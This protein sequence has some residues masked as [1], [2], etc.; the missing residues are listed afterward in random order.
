MTAFAFLFL[1]LLVL[2]QCDEPRRTYHN[3][4]VLSLEVTDVD[5]LHFLAQQYESNRSLDFW[6]EPRS[7][8]VVDLRIDPEIYD[9]FTAI[10]TEKDIPY[11]IM[12]EDVQV[13]MDQQMVGKIDAFSY[14][15]YNTLADIHTWIQS[16]PGLYPN[17]VSV[18]SVGKSFEG[19]DMLALRVTAGSGTKPRAVWFNGGIH[20][21]EWLSPATVIR[22]TYMLLESYH[23]DPEVKQILDNLEVYILPVF[24]VDGY[25]YT[26][27]TDRLWRKTRKPNPGSTCVGTDPNR[28]WGYQWGGEGASTNPCSETFRGATAFSEVETKKRS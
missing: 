13:A 3:S 17:F 10:L 20:A 22:M 28:N 1:S 15:Q 27:N 25:V 5:D 11:S 4:K 7:L 2:V 9:E 19:K 6:I 23:T 21:R 18:I 16:L 26:H 24:N 8:G 12:I 14:T